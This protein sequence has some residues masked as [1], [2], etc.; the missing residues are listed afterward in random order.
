LVKRLLR[1]FKVTGD[2]VECWGLVAYVMEFSTGQLRV[3]FHDVGEDNTPVPS[4]RM[5]YIIEG[6]D[7]ESYMDFVDF[8]KRHEEAVHIHGPLPFKMIAINLNH[9]DE[10]QRYVCPDCGEPSFQGP[11]VDFQVR[12]KVLGNAYVDPR[13]KNMQKRRNKWHEAKKD[14]ELEM[15]CLYC[16]DQAR[17]KCSK[18]RGRY[19]DA[20]CQRN[21]WSVHRE[22]CK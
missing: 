10:P 15:Q 22:L 8:V 5:G 13:G 2:G 1:T 18:C 3:S 16:G 6:L 14:R 19:C 17:L 9:P 7:E 11:H 12:K 4:V 20:E 21:D